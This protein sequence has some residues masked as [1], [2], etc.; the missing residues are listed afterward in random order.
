M[1]GVIAAIPDRRINQDTAKRYGVTVEYG[2]DGVISKHHY[3]YFDKDTGMVTGTKVRTVANKQFHATGSFDNVGLFGQ[4]AFREGGKYVTV[5]EG[6][7]DALAA[8]EMFDGKWPV[9][10]IRSGAASAAKDIKASLEWLLSFENIIICFDNDDAGKQATQAVLPLFPPNKVKAITLP[11]KDAGDML[12][13]RKIR[14]FVSAWWDAKT[15]KP[16]GIISFGEE[17]VWEKF[18]KRGTEEVIPLPSCFGDLN[19]KMNGGIVAGE[20]T[21]IG[22]LTSIGKTTMVSNL[23]NGFVTESEQTIGCIF[24]ESDVGETVENLLSPYAGVN[25]SNIPAAERDYASYHK[26][27]LEM[28][29]LN[30]LHI[31]DHQ[32]SSE[33][34]ALFGKIH[35]LVK[36]L[37]CDVIVIDPLQA[38]VKSNDNGTIDDFMDRCLKIAKNTGVSIILISHMRQPPQGRSSHDVGEYDL[39]G[40][41]SINQIAFNTILL[42]R[43][44]LADDEYERNC[45]FVQLVKCRRTGR[46]G[47]AGWLFYDINTARLEAVPPPVPNIINSNF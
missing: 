30:N 17:G 19:A 22:A 21:V 3:P 18:L 33:T 25:I 38:A 36:G 7:M 8:N 12:K 34:E 47:S 27:Y 42:S 16:D 23:I 41:T 40:S 11:M 20:V 37:E 31:L 24:L 1:T 28:S 15:F 4:Q 10:S 5:V 14:E 29:K 2:T 6:E 26:Q 13:A 32:G 44:K 9:V 46:T 35:Y 39:K 43:D 45:T